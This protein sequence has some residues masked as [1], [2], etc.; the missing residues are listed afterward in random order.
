[1]IDGKQRLASINQ[2]ITNR[3]TLK[4]LDIRPELNGISFDSLPSEDRE[5][6]ENA[7]LRSSLIRNWTD[8]N[9]LYAAFFRLNSGSLPLSPQELRKAL[10][11]SNL[12][13]TIEE[14]LLASTA[15][16][17]I[18]GNK[19]DKRMRD[20]ELVLRFIAFDRSL[21]DYRGNFK[22]LLDNTTKYFEEDWS[23]RHGEASE[24]LARLDTAL[25]IAHSIFGTDTFKKWLGDKYERVINRA[26]FDCIVRFFA[27]PAVVDA[28][29]GKE[30]AIVEAFKMTCQ[31]RDFRD[32]IEKTTKSV[33]ATFQ[34]IDRWGEA[35]CESIG[36]SYDKEAHKVV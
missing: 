23:T 32:A 6:L 25:N 35:L 30:S 17:V 18:F 12:L 36:L 31:D 3:F 4:G 10:V 16:K 27:T 11:G 15:F 28:L 29:T 22:E 19:L 5:Y 34:R 2:F 21:S 8:D 1:V 24:A 26:I 33:H 9:F 7:T 20:S 14:Y 13:D